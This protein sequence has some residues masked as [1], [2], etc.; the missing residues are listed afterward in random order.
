MKRHDPYGQLLAELRR[1]NDADTDMFFQESLQKSQP[2]V[3][4]LRLAY[5]NSPSNVDF[6]CHHIRAAYMLT[7]YPNYIE[8]LY[9]ILRLLPMETMQSVFGFDKLR[10]VFLGAGPA[11]EV[12]GWIAF[13]NDYIPQAKVAM[14]YLL[15]KYIHEWRTGQ[16]ITRYHLA[17]YYWPVGELII[18]PLEFDFLKLDTLQEAFVQRAIQISELLVMQN[19]LNDQ[20]GNKGAILEMLKNIFAQT[21]PGALF[22]LCDLNYQGAHEIMRELENHI[23]QMGMGQVLLPVKRNSKRYCACFDLPDIL[24]QNLLTGDERK[25]LIPRKYTDCYYTVIQRVDGIPF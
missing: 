13:L 7:Y 10:G 6:S 3:T 11:P 5:A 23:I 8:P 21:K 2:Y 25:F 15:D 19:C 14:A 16:E 18:R 9:E 20:L 4:A 12:L 1:V 24:R 22:I 17:P